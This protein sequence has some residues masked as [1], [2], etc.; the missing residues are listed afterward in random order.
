MK[1][2]KTTPEEIASSLSERLDALDAAIT[3]EIQIDTSVGFMQVAHAKKQ[4]VQ[5]DFDAHE[6]TRA[7]P[8]W[9][10]R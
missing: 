9:K 7:Y 10:N 3:P 5:F 4:E 2:G 1:S 8:N 6:F